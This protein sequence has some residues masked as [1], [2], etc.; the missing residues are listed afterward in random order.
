MA[1]LDAKAIRAL[2]V[3]EHATRA[4][5]TGTDGRFYLVRCPECGREN[6]VFTVSSGICCW[7]GHD[8][9]KA[10]DGEA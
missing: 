7:C 2:E 5:F 10:H 6:Y 1:R 9:N 4:N 8:G 3:R